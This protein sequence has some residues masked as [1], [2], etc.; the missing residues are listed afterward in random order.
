MTHVVYIYFIINAFIAGIWFSE[1]KGIA[2]TMLLFGLPLYI[3]VG[4]WSIVRIPIVWL[5]NNSLLLGW[6]RLYFTDYFSKM[7]NQTIE[8]RRAQYF[9][10]T[11]NINANK[12]FFLTNVTELKLCYLY[13]H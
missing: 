6:Y 7:D 8:I 9:G 3:I 4:V 5:E 1:N 13:Q 10:K 2:L 12:Y 11:K